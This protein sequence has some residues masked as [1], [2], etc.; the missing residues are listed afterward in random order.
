M[1]KNKRETILVID[2]RSHNL[3]LLFDLFTKEGFQVMV[4]RN[5]ENALEKV[6]V[7]PPDLI[8][9]DVMLPG[10]DGFETCTRLKQNPDYAE[11]PIVFMT[12]LNSVEDKVKGFEVGGVDYI[13]KPFQLDEM[14]IRVKAHLKIQKLQ[15]QL[16]EQNQKLQTEI[17]QRQIV[18]IALRETQ[19]NLEHK[20]EERTAQLK[21]TNALLEQKVID[22]QETEIILQ[23]ALQ[24]AESAA[25]AKSN[26]LA[27]MSHELRTPLNA[28]LGFT[29]LLTRDSSLN[30][31]RQQKLKIIHENS[32]N[33]LGLINN[34]LSI[35]QF[36]D[37]QVILRENWFDLHYFLTTIINL[38]RPKA[39]QKGLV[40]DLDLK[41]DIPH[42]IQTDERKLRQV[43]INLLDNAIAFTREGYVRLTIT[44]VLSQNQNDENER[45]L[46]LSFSVEDTGTGIPLEQLEHLFEPF[47][48]TENFQQTSK[49]IGLGLFLSQEFVRLL[50]GEIKV[51]SRLKMGSIF[52]FEIPAYLNSPDVIHSDQSKKRQ[53]IFPLEPIQYRLLIADRMVENCQTLFTMLKPLGFNVEI[54]SKSEECLELW[55]CWQ[56]HIL[57]LDLHL[58]KLDE[59]RLLEQIEVTKI[60][61][62]TI[63]IALTEGA[64]EEEWEGAIA[65]GCQDFISKPFREEVV[66]EKLAHHLSLLSRDRAAISLEHSEL[67]LENL[68]REELAIM[69]IQWLNQFSDA[70]RKINE[71]QLRQLLEEIPE[72]ENKLRQKITHLL[73]NFRFDILNQ[74]ID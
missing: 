1:D 41:E 5:G 42:S 64:S 16:S 21:A 23:Q 55:H 9:L 40:L 29:Q 69:P 49:G 60:N 11:I 3:E 63:A 31:E 54:T 33:L 32:E 45:S 24:A 28:I 47:T 62:K 35:A 38:F 36:D 53:L 22:L 73:D 61:H 37:S 13:T 20:V 48:L 15:N 68:T 44:P 4:A 25:Q 57:L 14:V 46:L 26:F 2:D 72:T 6:K 50:G 56:P 51:T 7:F 12:G 8:I 52:S 67:L 65:L 58:P 34:I 17:Q 70:T 74:L 19:S 30:S 27:Q 10:I 18:E 71:S 66:L 39:A 43:L 59:I